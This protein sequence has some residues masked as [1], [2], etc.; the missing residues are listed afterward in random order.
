[1]KVLVHYLSDDLMIR[2]DFRMGFTLLSVI[3]MTI[4]SRMPLIKNTFPIFGD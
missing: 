1:M 4:N 2:V 3:V